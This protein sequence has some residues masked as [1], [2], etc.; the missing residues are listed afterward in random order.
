MALSARRAAYLSTSVPRR[1]PQEWRPMP[2]NS[3]AAPT[4]PE[5]FPFGPPIMPNHGSCGAH[6]PSRSMRCPPLL[7]RTGPF[8]LTTAAQHCILRLHRACRLPQGRP[9]WVA[10]SAGIRSAHGLPA[11]RRP[12]P[13]QWAVSELW[14]AARRPPLK[15][16]LATA[17]RAW[18]GGF[19]WRV[20]TRLAG[21]RAKQGRPG[22]RSW[23]LG[24]RTR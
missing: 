15:E 8:P 21:L 23:R 12:P 3:S 20:W 9:A 6:S 22:G 19:S 10:L 17:V 5:R 7:L 4:S 1:Q 24:L 14:S 16:R 13:A 18:T 11:V 2:R